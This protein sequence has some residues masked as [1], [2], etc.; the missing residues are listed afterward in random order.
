MKIFLVGISCVGKTTIGKEFAEEIKYKFFDLDCE[1][2]NYFG[3][4][5]PKIKSEFLTDYDFRKKVCV[6]LKKV[7]T[8]NKESSYIISMPPSGLRDW[9]LKTIKNCDCITIALH[10][11]PENV[12]KRITF[13]DDDSNLIEVKLT[14]KQ[15]K[16]YLR[17][18][19]KD[20]TYFNRSYKRADYHIY[21]NGSSV[22]EGVQK[23]KELLN[24][25]ENLELKS[26]K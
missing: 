20:I 24:N 25:I 2:E 4:A 7:I 21:L 6:V 5:I 8:D 19:K 9:Y 23:I 17:E 3:E 1:I 15:K 12:L 18:I 10:D 16:Y 11:H 22:K 14:E 13:Y 26:N